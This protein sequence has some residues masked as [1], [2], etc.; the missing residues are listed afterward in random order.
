MSTHLLIRILKHSVRVNGVKPLTNEWLLNI[1]LLAEKEEARQ[2]LQ[3]QVY[4]YDLYY[5]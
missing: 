2:A 5:K 1:L 4:G 3:D